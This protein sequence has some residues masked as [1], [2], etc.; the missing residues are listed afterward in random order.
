MFKKVFLPLAVL[1]VIAALTIAAMC[2]IPAMQLDIP[3]ICIGP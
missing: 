3:K 2:S 1:A